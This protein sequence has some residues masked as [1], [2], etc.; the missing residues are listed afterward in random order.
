M[1]LMMAAALYV[2]CSGSGDEPGGGD[3]TPR[4]NE[5]AIA[6]SGNLKEKN[7]TRAGEVGLENYYKRFKV[8]AFKN[9]GTD[10]SVVNKVMNG[11]TVNWIA[12]SA[13]TSATNS[14]GWEY[15]NQQELNKMEQSV[16]YWDFDAAAYRFFGVAGGTENNVPTGAYDNETSPTKFIVTYIADAE[17]DHTTP[18]Y[19]RLWYGTEAKYGKPVQLE[20]IKPLSKVR[21]MFTFENPAEAPTTELSGMDFRPSSGT[22]IKMKGKVEVTYRLTGTADKEDFSADAESEG[23][24]AFIKDYYE[25]KMDGDDVV[26]PYLGADVSDAAFNKTYTVL[27]TPAGQGSYTLT[28]KVDGDPK[29]TIVPAEYM[30]WQPGYQY[31]YIFKVHVDGGVTIDNVQSAFTSWVDTSKDYTVYNW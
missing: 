25:K 26:P 20:F 2:G 21:F 16:K 4:P 22:T 13:G 17:N 31:T 12:N 7:V 6:F 5:K 9:T 29:T 11:Y 23:I 3:S 28:V 24:T 14:N 18:F 30:T 19:S 10:G 15:V 1:A 8:W 27:P